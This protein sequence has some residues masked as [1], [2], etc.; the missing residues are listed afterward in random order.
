MAAG[1]GRASHANPRVSVI[2]PTYNAAPF[3]ARTLNSILEQDFTDLEVVVVD[4]G[5]TDNTAAIVDGYEDRVRLIR[6]K[7]AGVAAA[8]NRAIAEARGDLIAFL[9]HDDVWYPGKLRRQVELLDSRP[10]VG[11]VYGNAQFIDLEDKRL[12]T[13]LSPPR[14][15]RGSVL[16]PLFLDC[17]IPLLTAV[18]RADLITR[19]G[20]FS[21]RWHIAEDYDLFLRAAEVTEVDYVDGI[22]AGYRIH[23]GNLSRSYARR[24]LE[25][26]EVL[27][28]CLSRD[29]GLRAQVGETAVRLRMS[30]LRCEPGHALVFQGH[31]REAA[32]YFGPRTAGQVPAAVPLW[33][34]GR[35]GPRFVM[36]ARRMYRWAREGAS[37]AT[38]RP[39][40]SNPAA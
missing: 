1:A 20:A 3:I 22:V 9:D 40:T 2:I 28:A 37:R 24:I 32:R 29:R 26:R 21:P 4:D 13:Y 8:R 12:W 23:P 14:L 15:H 34:A 16:V 31:L 35:L 39:A 7:N 38:A 30:G 6:Q 27:T 25:E 5:S 36:T 19:I 11:V 17:F 18:V 10:E 33:L